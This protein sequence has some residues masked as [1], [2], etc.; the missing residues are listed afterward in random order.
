MPP[1]VHRLC[2]VAVATVLVVVYVVWHAAPAAAAASV[3]RDGP[4]AVGYL[5]PV[6]APVVDPFRAP[7]TPYGPGHRGIEYG[8]AP[9]TVVHAAAPGTVTFAGAVAATRWVTV[10]HADGIRTTYGPLDALDVAA[11][12]HVELGQPLGTTLGPLLL[13]AR[14]G[15]GYLD[16]ALLF[17]DGTY[18]H[19]VPEPRELPTVSSSSFLPDASSFAGS[20]TS[21][22]DWGVDRTVRAVDAVRAVTPV[23]IT[24]HTV[25]ALLAW[26]RRARDCTPADAVL[27]APSARRVAV[28][29]GGLGSS[30][31]TAAVDDVDTGALGYAAGDVLRFSYAGGATTTSPYGPR[32]TTGDLRGEGHALADVLEAAVAAAPASATVDVL[33]HSQGGLVTRLAL[34][35][36]AQRSPAVLARLGVVVTIATPHDGAAL[37]ALAGDVAADPLG[38]VLVGTAGAATGTEVR[39][40]DTVVAQLAP[41]SALLDELAATPLPPGPTY[42]SIAARGDPVVPS[43]EAHLD[44]ATNVIVPVA[45]VGAH[46]AVTAAPATTRVIAGAIAGLPPPCQTASDAVVDAVAGDLLQD[47]EQLLA[48]T[49]VP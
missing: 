24:V 25:A 20:I 7:A 30:S 5:P 12:D 10:A 39:T 44:G 17:G 26:Q 2:A 1:T 11:G 19:L 48:A 27:P 41:G 49:R 47:G 32:D 31:E 43:P 4:P 28:L 22:A 40:D 16:P 38:R 8:T 18:V 9:G 3:V 45:G 6:D 14:L 15:D 46:A 23:P 29:V 21:L 42:V 13:T 35:E 33:A 34:D 36:L 37:A